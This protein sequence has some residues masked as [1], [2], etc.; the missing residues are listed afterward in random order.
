M[1]QSHGWASLE[2]V[3]LCLLIPENHDREW[4]GSQGTRSISVQ[5]EVDGDLTVPVVYCHVISRVSRGSISFPSS[6][7][8][9]C[10]IILRF[11]RK[12]EVIAFDLGKP[13]Q[14]WGED[15]RK[16]SALILNS[17]YRYFGM[18]K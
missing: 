5:V 6:F 12:P 14:Q 1:A 16:I 4:N 11:E 17:N 8:F 15:E 2:N 13:Q 18:E 7:S 3:S 10:S 9:Q